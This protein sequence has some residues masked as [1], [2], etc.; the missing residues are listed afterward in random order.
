[1]PDGEP[2]PQP[3]CIMT[4][5]ER[6]EKEAELAQTRL[7]TEQVAYRTAKTKLKEARI[8]AGIIKVDDATARL[9]G[10]IRD[11]A[12]LFRSTI[13]RHVLKTLADALEGKSNELLDLDDELF[14]QQNANLRVAVWLDNNVEWRFGGQQSAKANLEYLAAVEEAKTDKAILAVELLRAERKW[15]R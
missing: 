10:E 5:L 1:M 8:K 14:R 7:V 2:I 6:L 11:K 15:E 3:R 12:E 9:C 4:E 13:C